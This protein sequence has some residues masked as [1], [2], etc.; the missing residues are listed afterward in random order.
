M[1]EDEKEGGTCLA[2]EGLKGQ[3]SEQADSGF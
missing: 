2:F 3:G 1:T